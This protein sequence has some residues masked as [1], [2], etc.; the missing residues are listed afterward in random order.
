[1]SKKIVLK[2]GGSVLRNQDSVQKIINILKSYEQK[3]VIVVSA[4]L[5]ITD[6]L[7]ES[8]ENLLNEESS[9]NRIFEEILHLKS[10]IIIE[11]IDDDKIRQN[12]LDE[13]NKELR[14]L[15]QYLQGIYYIR[16]IPEK[17][18]D[19]VLSFGEKLSVIL[20]KGVFADKNIV[21]E[22]VY[23]E[24]AGL[25]TDGIFGNASIDLIAAKKQVP[26]NFT[27]DIVY[28]VP[29][30]YGVSKKSELTLLGRGGTDYSAAAF[31]YCLDA[32]SLDIWKDVNGFMSGDPKHINNPQRIKHLTYSEAAE[33]AYFGAGILH[34]RTVEPVRLANIPIRLFNINNADKKTAQT[35][36]DNNISI[37]PEIS[38]SVT[39]DRNTG[40]LKLQGPGVGYIP[41]ILSEITKELHLHNININSVITS[42]IAINLL[43]DKDIIDKAH[44]LI[45]K[46]NLQVLTNIIVKKDVSLIAVV[47]NGMTEAYGVAARIL[48][49]VS[50]HGINIQLSS[51]G[52]SNAVTYLIVD[53]K[54]T[55]KALTEIHYTLFEKNA[56][57][58]INSFIEN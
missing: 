8:L 32:K 37:H 12:T 23:P 14:N 15:R 52:A 6:K 7:K 44:Q 26:I 29:G 42:Q 51:I 49:A 11:L 57:Q 3:P 47:G 56:K 48:S 24:K 1:M 13:L 16:Y 27:K 34:P 53:E 33:L 2:I 40:I 9:L 31:A 19:Y 18:Y 39:V 41:G 35:I 17:A 30:F 21:S 43:I 36:I 4:F 25:L 46:L 58:N 28:L 10:S 55:N 38:K 20:L 50:E 45:S 5:G 54:D 22:I